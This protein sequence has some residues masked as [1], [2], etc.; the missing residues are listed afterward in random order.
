MLDSEPLD[1][2][3]GRRAEPDE[4]EEQLA[5]Q[6]AEV[7]A[8][9]ANSL[10]PNVVSVWAELEPLRSKLVGLVDRGWL[11]KRPDAGLHVN[12]ALARVS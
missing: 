8:R 5:R 11:R 6:L 9:G 3:T 10:S 1:R 12:V 7:R 4:P 2:I